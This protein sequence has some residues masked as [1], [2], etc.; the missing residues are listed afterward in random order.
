MDA[1]L[2]TVAPG[3]GDSEQRD[4]PLAR[5]ADAVR[6]A[7]PGAAGDELVGKIA[8]LVSGLIPDGLEQIAVEN[9]QLQHELEMLQSVDGL[10]GLSVNGSTV[11]TGPKISSRAMRRSFVRASKMV[12]A[13]KWPP[14]SAG[15]EGRAPS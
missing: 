8:S 3:A 5:I 2:D 4:E 13:T 9:A 1:S 6:E 12:G 10:T 15:S 14:A 11:M 7:V